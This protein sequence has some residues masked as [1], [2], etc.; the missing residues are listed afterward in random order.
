MPRQFRVSTW[1]EIN[2]KEANQSLNKNHI[3]L[4]LLVL[5]NS[6]VLCFNSTADQKLRGPPSQLETE[7]RWVESESCKSGLHRQLWL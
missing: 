3:G 6:A 5:A 2:K 1:S 7:L 4:E